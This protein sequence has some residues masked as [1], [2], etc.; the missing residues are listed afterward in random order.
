MK[1]GVNEFKKGEYVVLNGEPY[2]ILD[3]EHSAMQQR[4]AVVKLRVKSLKTGKVKEESM[5]SSQEAE[6]AEIMK[7]SAVFIYTRNGEF[8]FHEKGNPGNRFSLKEEVLG[9]FSKWLK[10]RMEIITVVFKEQVVDIIL[11]IKVE[12]EVIETPPAIKGATAAGGNKPAKIDT[13]AT[14]QVPMFVET[15]NRIVVNTETGE[16][17][18]RA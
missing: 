18:S 15:G 11:P 8:W 13:G 16:Y 14:V 5:T 1:K 4:Q 3:K 12:Y 9:D 2:Q 7:K 6:E 17:D 10:E